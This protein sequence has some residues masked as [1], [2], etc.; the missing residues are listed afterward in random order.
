M[1]INFAFHKGIPAI[2]GA[3]T[4]MTY[5][6]L[7]GVAS[8]AVVGPTASDHQW[9]SVTSR[10]CESPLTYAEIVCA[11][12]GGGS[13]AVTEVSGSE[14][15]GYNIHDFGGGSISGNALRV[16][17]QSS[18][19]VVRTTAIIEETYTLLG[20]DGST[21]DN[22]ALDLN[23]AADGFYQFIDDRFGRRGSGHGYATIKIGNFM[24][25][26][27][28]NIFVHGSSAALATDSDDYRVT[29]DEK[30]KPLFKEFDLLASTTMNVTTG[31]DFNLAFMF[32][33]VSTG[34][35]IVDGLNTGLIN[36]DVPDGYTLTALGGTTLPETASTVPVPAALPLFGTAL[37]GLGFAGYRRRK[38]QNA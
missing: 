12:T 2:I 35:V 37:I 4:I 13:L 26:D 38:A 31:M 14:A 25:A 18:S 23:F 28:L 21:G 27:G 34:S 20:P 1:K 10:T 24:S 9:I 3:G 32:Q 11:A 19:Y 33:V 5:V 16:Y 17:S 29:S 15:Q 7:S 36:F 22:I 8:A 6:A 30:T